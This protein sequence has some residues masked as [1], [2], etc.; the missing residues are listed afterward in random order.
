M[1]LMATKSNQFYLVSEDGVG[2][3]SSFNGVCVV[4]KKSDPNIDDLIKDL[5]PIAEVTAERACLTCLKQHLGEY[6]TPLTYTRGK[7]ERVLKDE[8]VQ[9]LWDCEGHHRKH[10]RFSRANLVEF[11]NDLRWEGAWIA[12]EYAGELF[13]NPPN[14]ATLLMDFVSGGKII[15]VLSALR[16]YKV[17]EEYPELTDIL[18]N[19]FSKLDY[20]ANPHENKV[21][22]S[23]EAGL[24]L[25]YQK[26][27]EL[28]GYELVSEIAA[29]KKE[30]LALFSLGKI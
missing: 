21:Y 9:V 2:I 22:I 13:L 3:P 28:L 29:N 27:F 5:K 18:T 15:E 16:F 30:F 7:S 6:S 26:A 1:Q 23:Y 10:P 12:P 25:S 14:T 8:L 24:R 4:Q 20:S 17:R 11:V 19:I